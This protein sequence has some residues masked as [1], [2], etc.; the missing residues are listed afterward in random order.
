MTITLSGCPL[1]TNH[2]WKHRV[3]RGMLHSYM[4]KE[5]TAQKEGWKWEARA[6]WKKQPPLAQPLAV[7]ITLYFPDHRK[8]DWDNY[9]KLS[10]DAL[11]GI[12]WKDDS[13]ITFASVRKEIDRAKPRIEIEVIPLRK[14]A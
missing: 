9:H 1:S 6:Q 5:G 14:A 13:L 3:A 12:V 11:N 8:R 2:V 4:T 10:C 7:H